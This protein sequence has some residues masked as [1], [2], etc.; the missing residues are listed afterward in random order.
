MEINLFLFSAATFIEIYCELW[1]HPRNYSII[2]PSVSKYE[3][4]MKKRRETSLTGQAID[5]F[6][7]LLGL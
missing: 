1:L 4:E 6:H 5:T 7:G 2:W 3:E